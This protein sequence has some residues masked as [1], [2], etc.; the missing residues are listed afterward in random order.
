MFFTGVKALVDLERVI[1]NLIDL[2]ENKY[3]YLDEIYLLTKQQTDA[4]ESSNM[5]FLALLIDE[6]QE[7]IDFVRKL[8]SQF[9]GIVDDLKTLYEIKTLDELETDNANIAV[10]KSNITKVM[11]LLRNI[12]EL[13]EYNKNKIIASKDIL[14]SKMQ[15]AKNGK[16]AIKQYGGLL[17]YSDSFFIDKKIR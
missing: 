2:S 5:G 10:L 4:I 1:D 17:G 16:K 6:K 9:E 8:D 14:E 7:R 3:E 15:N 12:V 13:E 11:T